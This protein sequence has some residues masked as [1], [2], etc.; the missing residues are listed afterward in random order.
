ME[1][2]EDLMKMKMPELK[3]FCRDNNIAGFSKLNKRAL[4]NHI[5]KHLKRG[6]KPKKKEPKGCHLPAGCST[7]RA[8]GYSVKDIRELA[9]SC[10]VDPKG[11][12]RKTLCN[13]IAEALRRGERDRESKEQDDDSKYDHDLEDENDAEI[14]EDEKEAEDEVEVPCFGGN[15]EALIRMKAKE[16][17]ALLSQHVK[18]GRP[19]KKEGLIDYLCALG[20]DPNTAPRCD[21]E[22]RQ[23]CDGE[24]VCDAK[25]KLC[26]PPAIAAK[27]IKL[28]QMSWGGRKII[29]TAKA[30][31]KL[32]KK[33][34][35]APQ[36]R[37]EGVL[38][39]PG[40]LGG[41]EKEDEK[42]EDVLPPPGYLGGDEKEDEKE[43]N[44]FPDFGVRPLDCENEECKSDDDCKACGDDWECGDENLC[45]KKYID[46]PTPPS[47][48]KQKPREGEPVVSIEDILRQIQNK[49]DTNI[50]GM[51]AVQREVLS[52]LGLL[53]SA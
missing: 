14:L 29:G 46:P 2:K 7:K 27:R 41:D 47:R 38:P 13:E 37:E 50:V 3:Q 11:K 6:S 12:T 31:E 5:L 45:K 30:L 18:E 20:E 49:G 33:L 42:E 1:S 40:Y 32:R 22:K 51:S 17:R 53:S 52:C 43:E 23:F 8:S 4:V 15:R 44:V 25:A 26:L 21:P 24:L 28:Q 48:P 19:V 9:L 36:E 39:P 35:E 34:G 16:L 10:G